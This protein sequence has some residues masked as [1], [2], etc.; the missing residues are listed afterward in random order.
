VWL[1]AERRGFE[2]PAGFVV[3]RDE[4]KRK[5]GGRLK[6]ELTGGARVAVI[7]GEGRKEAAAGLMRAGPRGEVFGPRGVRRKE[8]KVLGQGVREIR[9]KL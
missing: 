1:G 8:V 3:P 2:I 4:E 9:P 6:I 5:E 7:V